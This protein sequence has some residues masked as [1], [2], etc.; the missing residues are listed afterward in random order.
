M[1]S[2]EAELVALTELSLQVNWLKNL[3]TQD[4]KLSLP[5]TPL[6]CDN[7]ST[8]TLAKDPIA[9]GRTKHIEVR[10][11]KVQELVESKEVQV[12]RIPNE[13]QAADIL[14]KPLPR[15]AFMKFKEQLQVQDQVKTEDISK[16]EEY[17][18]VVGECLNVRP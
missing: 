3:A 2:A 11:R 8:V 1:S 10:H 5:V 17:I 7:N 14:T 4:L 15:L 16:V 6:L 13:E 9:S 18:V 12:N